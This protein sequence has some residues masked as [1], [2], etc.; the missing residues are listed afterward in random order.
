MAL[1]EGLF[2]IQG[3]ALEGDA[4]LTAQA[5]HRVVATAEARVCLAECALGV[6][7]HPPARVDDRKQEIA[8]LSFPLVGAV[9]GLELGKLFADLFQHRVSLLPVEAGTGSSLLNGMG[10]GERGQRS[11]NAVHGRGLRPGHLLLGA[12]DDMPAGLDGPRVG[13]LGVAEDVRVA[14]N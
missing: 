10:V 14:P 5:F 11:G 7:V 2:F 13:S 12:L 9:R 6:Q 8:E 1:P 4:P 3:E